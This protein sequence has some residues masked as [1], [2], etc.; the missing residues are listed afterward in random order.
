MWLWTAF[1]G[2]QALREVRYTHHMARGN[3]P[4][5]ARP[6]PTVRPMT[7]R[8]L[9]ARPGSLRSQMFA[10]QGEPER[11]QLTG[12]ADV[13]EIEPA[14]R[15]LC[16][17]CRRPMRRVYRL[18]R[19]DT[20][21]VIVGT[22]CCRHYLGITGAQAVR[23]R[24]TQER[25]S[26]REKRA[27]QERLERETIAAERFARDEDVYRHLRTRRPAIGPPASV[28]SR[29][30]DDLSQRLRRDRLYILTDRQIAAA[31]AEITREAERAQRWAAGQSRPEI[32]R[33][34][35][36][37]GPLTLTVRRIR[38]THG[39]YGAQITV[40]GDAASGHRYWYRTGRTTHAGQ[41][42]AQVQ[43]G[44]DLLIEHATVRGQSEDH[45]ITFL[46]RAR[47]RLPH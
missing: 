46:T 28:R 4:L 39:T 14:R 26:A 31:R 37:I 27:Q 13:G 10:R 20:E 38:E 1:R 16:E 8:A 21:Q 43:P 11:W 23:V 40:T 29:L 36:S 33:A 19:G 3:A 17:R 44:M 7:A 32:H 35:E 34:G 2:G 15:P 25:R 5:N 30:L 22:G 41:L 6:A 24:V 9:F 12:V 18:E 42:L 47:F 45:A